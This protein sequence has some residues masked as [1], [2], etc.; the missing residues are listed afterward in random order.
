[1]NVQLGEQRST[2]THF[3]LNATVM[4]VSLD[5]CLL[6]GDIHIGGHGI[7]SSRSIRLQN[8]HMQI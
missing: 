5:G 3:Y 7:A 2:R 4:I 1:M 8:M 6:G